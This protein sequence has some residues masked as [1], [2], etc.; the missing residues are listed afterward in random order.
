MQ[1]QARNVSRLTPIQH[2][3]RRCGGGLNVSRT[4]NK[5]LRMCLLLPAHGRGGGVVCG[6]VLTRLKRAHRSSSSVLVLAALSRF[7]YDE[8]KSLSSL[9][10]LSRCCFSASSVFALRCMN[11]DKQRGR[12]APAKTWTKVPE[13]RVSYPAKKCTLC[14][15]YQSVYIYKMRYTTCTT[16]DQDRYLLWSSNL[17]AS[18]KRLLVNC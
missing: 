10:L 9:S 13:S 2:P 15:L 14:G 17:I 7:A 18:P 1:P 16:Y 4:D 8:L 11:C 3:S 12:P 6:V 5:A